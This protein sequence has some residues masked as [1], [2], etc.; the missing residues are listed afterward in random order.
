MKKETTYGVGV[1][2]MAQEAIITNSNQNI[3]TKKTMEQKPRYS[4]EVS[5][6]IQ[7]AIITNTNLTATEIQ[8][9]FDYLVWL[10]GLPAK[11]YEAY[12]GWRIRLGLEIMQPD[13]HNKSTL[14]TLTKS[15]Q[16]ARKVGNWTQDGDTY[17]ATVDGFV[18]FHFWSNA[19]AHLDSVIKKVREVEV[20]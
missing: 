3:D 17:S 9:A 11:D 18:W 16:I 10:D 15:L 1:S 7:R 2:D 13:G 8:D 14:N 5:D 4:K 6:M 12:K 20:Q 19:K